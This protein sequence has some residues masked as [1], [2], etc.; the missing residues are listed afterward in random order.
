MKVIDDP[1]TVNAFCMAG[2]KMAI[3]TG[4]LMKIDPTDDELAARRRPVSRSYVV[5]VYDVPERTSVTM[6]S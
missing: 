2:G 3:Y 6:A 4:L 1:K 5:R